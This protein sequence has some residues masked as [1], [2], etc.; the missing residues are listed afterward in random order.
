[1]SN[2]TTGF[3]EVEINICSSRAEVTKGTRQAGSTSRSRSLRFSAFSHAFT[4]KRK[5]YLLKSAFLQNKS[6]DNTAGSITGPSLYLAQLHNN[7]LLQ[8]I[9]QQFL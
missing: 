7:I 6:T 3:A 2:F 9:I 5:K 1:M 8:P 4:L